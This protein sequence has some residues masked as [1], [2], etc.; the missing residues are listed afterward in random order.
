MLRAGLSA[1]PLLL[2]A[3]AALVATLFAA[4]L[5]LEVSPADAQG[6]EKPARPIGL[7]VD[8]T[9]GSLDVGVDWND[10]PGAADYL[11]RWRLHGPDQELNEGVRPTSSDTLITVADYS[12]WVV[13]VQACN[14][15][16]CGPA[17]AR[18]A[19]V[20]PAEPT[21]TAYAATTGGLDLWAAWDSVAGADA[22]SVRWRRHDGSF[23]TGS[24]VSVPAVDSV[25]HISAFI[26]VA[27]HG[28]WVVRVEACNDGACGTSV[29][30]P[31]DLPIT[32]AAGALNVAAAWDAV[33]GA[34]SYEV[35][36]RRPNGG[37]DAASLVDTNATN[38]DFTVSGY[39]RW[40]VRVRACRGETCG[41]GAIQEVGVAPG[42]PANLAVRAG[43]G[44][45]DLT[46]TWDAA[47]GADVY[48]VRWR[49]AGEDFVASNQADTAATG[50]NIAVADYGA[51][52]V[53][54]QACND[55]GCG[56]PS[57][58]E[59]EVEPPPPPK[60]PARPTGLE[61]ATTAG[62]LEASVDWDDVEGADDYLVRWRRHGPGQELNGGLRP[63]A[64]DARVTVAGA[65]AW[66]VRV[67]ACND[68]GCGEPASSQFEVT[69][70]GLGPPANLELAATLFNLDV[71]APGTP[72][73]ARPATG[74]TGGR[75][76]AAARRAA[77]WSS[78]MSA[79]PSPLRGRAGGISTWRPATAKAAETRRSGGS[80]WPPSLSRGPLRCRVL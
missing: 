77:R 31:V 68:A 72:E 37:F 64:S 25:E 65:G 57:A 53:Q 32:V 74:W 70:A 27:G 24:Q 52:A 40:W 45:L 41:P 44:A 42:R 26:T 34:D 30:Q 17:I 61:V 22:Y 39:G 35:R 15:S 16:G 5:W 19:S 46:A 28:D 33:D 63:T 12:R 7:T 66:V 10:V 55:A 38:A 2:A 1:R 62:S 9:P 59:F 36:W 47:A 67:Q 58:L 18:T 11:V 60:P 69:A 23:E 49:P 21:I 78:G 20:T 51:W 43:T 75:W 8:T 50:A 71:T 76:T 48:R 4:L 54:V 13:R 80:T 79:P 6:G 56:G 73:K 14:D 3:T 29:T